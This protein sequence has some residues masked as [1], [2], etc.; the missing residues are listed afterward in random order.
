[1][2]ALEQFRDSTRAWLEENCPP[3]MRTPMVPEEIVWGG[4]DALFANPESKL[5]LDRMA[6]KGWTC[7]TWPAEYGG[8][9]LSSEEAKILAEELGRINARVALTSFG[10]S[11]L[12]PVLLEYGTHEQK[13]EHI[14]KIIRGEIRWCQ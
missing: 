1:M 3:S 4:R 5:W 9:G 11:M 10:I 2:L 14:P 13:M 7:P 6:D 8:G 12:G